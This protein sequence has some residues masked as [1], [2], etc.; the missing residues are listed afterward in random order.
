MLDDES[1]LS[2][3]HEQPAYQDRPSIPEQLIRDDATDQWRQVDHRI[4]A[5]VDVGRGLVV[6]LEDLADHV[7]HQQRT[8]AVEAEPL[9]HLREEQHRQATRM[10]TGV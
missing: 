7:E 4:V 9:P 8:H 1:E 5:A 3:R 10:A 2:H 6:V